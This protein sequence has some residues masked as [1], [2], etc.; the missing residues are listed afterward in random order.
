MLRFESNEVNMTAE[1]KQE[2]KHFLEQLYQDYQK[3]DTRYKE[4]EMALGQLQ[5]EIHGYYLN[6]EDHTT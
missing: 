1:D 2:S 4:K 5:K 3:K 6:P